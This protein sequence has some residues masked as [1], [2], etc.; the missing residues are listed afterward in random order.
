MLLYVMDPHDRYI[1]PPPYD[2]LYDPDYH[3]KWLVESGGPARYHEK[4]LYGER[5]DLAP[6]DIRHFIALYDG[7]IRYAD[8]MLARLWSY[9]KS[10]GLLDKT[11]VVVTA[12][13]G[14]EFYDHGGLKHNHT[15]YNEL[16]SIPVIFHYE[17]SLPDGVVL[18]G[19]I[20]QAIDTVPTILDCAGIPKPSVMQGE[21]ILTLLGRRNGP[22]RDY[23]LS[24]NLSVNAKAFISGGWKYI[25]HFG[26][27]INYCKKYTEGRELYNIVDDPKERRNLYETSPDMAR[28]LYGRMM[29]VLPLAERERIGKKAAIELDESARQRLR[30]L[31]Y[32]Q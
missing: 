26:S 2:K 18:D 30:T 10:E 23:A 17:G 27:D 7:E 8:A 5:V 11:L 13:H 32:V 28:H 3:G 12:D 19:E 24:E 16:I 31:G 6:R 29:T 1:P 14:E 4:Q 15:L 20:L 22:W 21:S 9:L 25:H